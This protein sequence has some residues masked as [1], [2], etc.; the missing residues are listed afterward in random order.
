MN[1]Y[2]RL[3]S[4]MWCLALIFLFTGNGIAKKAKKPKDPYTF[5]IVTEVAR[6]PV[7]S[8]DRTGTCWVFGGISFLESEVLRKGGEQVD[9]S[10]MYIVRRNY[11]KRALN[12]V[13]MHGAAGFHQGGQFHHVTNWIK[14]F[15]ALPESVYTGKNIE[16]TIH[17][18]GELGTI[19]KAFLDAVVKRRGRKVT[20]RWMEAFEAILDIYLGTPPEEFEYKG[21][22]YTPESFVS[23]YL[24]LDMNDYI[25]VTSYSHHPY[26]RTCG[27]EIPD[28]WDYN[29][30]YLNLPIDDFEKT[31][32][33]ALK[34]G[35]SVAWDGDVSEQ[36]FMH[37]MGFAVVPKKEST[38]RRGEKAPEI[39]APVEEKEIT[40][41]LRQ[42][43]FDNQTTTDDHLVHIV[44]IAK[45]QRG[46]KFYLT[47]NSWGAKANKYKGYFYMSRSY[48]RLKTT[49]VMINRH[50]LPE[51]IRQKIKK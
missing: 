18:H 35:Y 25:E 50:A 24:K 36:G 33:H 32:D 3:I 19:L 13:R 29:R 4:M 44:G 23:D 30:D 15:G 27:L 47:K 28:N 1:I 49:N 9:L 8:Q 43:T 31:V 42:K 39:T 11:P 34:N 46:E 21:V 41:E 17:N 5:K 2:K 48:F 6:T 10:E 26:F 12:Y 20:P 7:T 22:T 38:G 14:E 51:D 37:R 16:E 45:D 40:Q